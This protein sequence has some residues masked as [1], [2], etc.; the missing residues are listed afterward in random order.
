MPIR[1]YRILRMA[2]PL[3]AL[4]TCAG[5]AGMAVAAT[6]GGPETAAEGDCDFTITWDPIDLA[7]MFYVHPGQTKHFDF[8]IL[9]NGSAPANYTSVVS[10]NATPPNGQWVV[11][12][13]RTAVPSLPA[14]AHG[15]MRLRAVAPPD[16]ADGDRID[17]D[18]TATDDATACAVSLQFPVHIQWTRELRLSGEQQKSGNNTEWLLFNLFVQNRGDRAEPVQIAQGLGVGEDWPL[19]I[20]IDRIDLAP[21]ESA[22]FTV[23]IQIPENAPG[24]VPGL[25]QITAYS[26]DDTTVRY[27]IQLTVVPRTIINI[28]MDSDPSEQE[29]FGGD[30]AL[31]T[32][33]ITNDGNLPSAVRI[34]LHAQSPTS[35]P[36]WLATIN[37]EVVYLRGGE[38]TT[39]QLQVYV[40]PQAAAGTRV[41][42]IVSGFSANYAAEGRAVAT[43]I[44]G[45]E[46]SVKIT[47]APT[48]EV[49][50]GVEGYSSMTIANEGNRPA[51]G[52]VTITTSR[53]EWIVSLGPGNGSVGPFEVAPFGERTINWTARAPA[54][55][56]AGYSHSVAL[57]VSTDGCGS[58]VALAGVVVLPTG[59]VDIDL[60][61]ATA[62]G[63]RGDD[64]RFD[65][66]LTSHRNGPVAV[67]VMWALPAPLDAP[68]DTWFLVS[69]KNG[70][71]PEQQVLDGVVSL[72]P[73]E[74]A[75]LTLVQRV[76]AETKLYS[77]EVLVTLT[78]PPKIP[79]TFRLS[80]SVFWPDLAIKEVY[81]DD[82]PTRAGDQVHFFVTITNLGT[83]ESGE[84]TLTMAMGR[85][86]L[87]DQSI[88]PIPPGRS[89]T[90]EV[91]WNATTG[92]HTL[93]FFVSSPRGS[94]EFDTE[95]NDAILQVDVQ[96]ADPPVETSN[97]VA[98]AIAAVAVEATAI[99][100]GGFLIW[101]HR[102]RK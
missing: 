55:T 47:A 83:G 60:P 32:I 13:D 14:G 18:I 84:A 9:N 78:T 92:I 72:A 96:G 99:L 85:T 26:L 33:H 11:D 94:L 45:P 7:N 38:S 44:V 90:Y 24:S 71:L 79:S 81:R 48:L 4:V 15:G 67:P 30:T 62:G 91:V 40:A 31:F 75:R 20:S 88:L 74:T 57:N 95:N 41:E 36:G 21:G 23:S 97:S 42:L 53:N 63:A 5:L 101:R 65:F 70:T 54:G 35:F 82:I 3:I 8:S 10:T 50:P 46:C 39:F 58:A 98:W 56:I 100:L 87:E 29:V 34:D 37:R 80:V 102:H 89:V 51:V 69:G 1:G 22:N 28:V 49:L 12:L 61:S 2:L 59:G 25:F 43:T 19:N 64:A 6:S 86:M 93:G 76:P 17:I 68:G 77:F 27:N 73:F 16:A 66:T 52:N